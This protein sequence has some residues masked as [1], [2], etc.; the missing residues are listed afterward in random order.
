MSG[1]SHEPMRWSRVTWGGELTSSHKDMEQEPEGGHG[2]FR[3]GGM[4]QEVPLGGWG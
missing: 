2:E 1:K 4:E 3:S